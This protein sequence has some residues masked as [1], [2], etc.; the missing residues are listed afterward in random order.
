[1]NRSHTPD[2]EG[3]LKLIRRIE[4]DC[5]KNC[6]NITELGKKVKVLESQHITKEL[7]PAVWNFMN[8]RIDQLEKHILETRIQFIDQLGNDKTP[9]KCPVCDGKGN[10][11]Q[12]V[13]PRILKLEFCNTCEG[14]GIVWN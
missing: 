11:K 4:L 12:E 6:A 2:N 7:D 10:S 14:K 3:L 1:M 5:H 8:E 9:H 13:E